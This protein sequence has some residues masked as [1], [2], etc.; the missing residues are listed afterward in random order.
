MSSELS[1]IDQV[2]ARCANFAIA[3]GN[4]SN[5]LVDVILSQQ[6]VSSDFLQGLYCFCP[7]LLLEGDDRHIFQLFFRLV[8]VLERCGCLSSSDALT[9]RE[10][11]ATLRL[12]SVLGRDIV[13]QREGQNRLKMLLF[14]CSL[15]TVLCREGVWCES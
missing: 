2:P 15:I 13:T 9:S 7:E 12:S 10:E 8:R 11:F 4:S 14:I 5:R 1:C 3:V 6:V